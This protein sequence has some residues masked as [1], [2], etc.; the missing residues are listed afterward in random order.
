MAE[1]ILTARTNRPNVRSTRWKLASDDGAPAGCGFWPT[2]IATPSLI[3]TLYGGDG[4]S[5]QI[6]D[7][8]DG[9]TRLDDVN[10]RF[11]LAL[12]DTAG[13]EGALD[14]GKETAYFIGEGVGVRRRGNGNVWRSPHSLNPENSDGE[15]QIS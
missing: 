10:R 5:G 2:T 13:S 6:H 15:R 9:L 3:K 11:T 8:L 1:T 12:H 7:D 14:L 4:H